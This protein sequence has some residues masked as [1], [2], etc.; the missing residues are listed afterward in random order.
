MS[1]HA[2]EFDGDCDVTNY[3]QVSG[4]AVHLPPWKKNSIP[5]LDTTV[6]TTGAQE[7]V[8]QIT[9]WPLALSL[10]GGHLGS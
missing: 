2:R 8:K 7:L 9:R 6:S 10:Y 4:G 5:D 1:R 3:A